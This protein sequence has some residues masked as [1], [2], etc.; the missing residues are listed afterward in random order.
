MMELQK[1]SVP[2]NSPQI[3]ETKKTNNSP[4]VSLKKENE[5][6][7]LP[8]SNNAQKNDSEI[9]KENKKIMIHSDSE[10][11]N[12]KLENYINKSYLNQSSL[13]KNS[14]GDRKNNS[15]EKVDNKKSSNMIT[16]NNYNSGNSNNNNNVN[17]KFDKNKDSSERKMINSHSK[18]SVKSFS[19]GSS[20]NLKYGHGTDD[21]VRTLF[22]INTI[23]F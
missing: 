5:K 18:E 16:S 2:G 13:Q 17:N 23:F 10:S 4:L 12:E 15:N 14:N 11:E 3:L 7:E 8:H 9:F 21:K 19:S 1:K 6:Y 20:F 22:K